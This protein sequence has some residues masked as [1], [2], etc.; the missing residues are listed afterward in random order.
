MCFCIMQLM[1]ETYQSKRERWQRLM[2]TLP[3]GLREHIALRNVEAVAALPPQAQARLLEAIRSGLKRLPLAVEKLK[4][5]PNLSVAELLEPTAQAVIPEDPPIRAELA[6]I[7]QKC[8]PDMPRI[9]AEALAEASLMDIARILARTHEQM[10]S[11]EHLKTDFVMM[12][13]YGLMRQTLDQLEEIIGQTPSLQQALEKSALP[14]K[15]N[16]WRK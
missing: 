7:I 13:L 1:S 4:A 9:S 12:V 15:S 16:D 10:L 3:A 14:W 5:N 6:D 8:F 11:S 2:E